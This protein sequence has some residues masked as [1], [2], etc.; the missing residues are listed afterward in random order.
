MVMRFL[1]SIVALVVV[2]AAFVLAPAP[3][4]GQA[5]AAKNIPRL[6]DGKPD[7]NGIWDR[8]RI[9]DITRDENACGSGAPITA[10]ASRTGSGELP[11][12]AW[13]QEQM[14]GPRFDYAA[15][16][17]PWGYTRAMQ[18]AYPIEIM[19]TPKRLAYLFESNNVFHVI[20]TDGRKLPENAD[21]P[22]W[23]RRPAVTKAT[24]SSSRPRVSMAG[25]GSTPRNIHQAISCASPN[26]SGS[27]TPIISNM[28]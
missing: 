10:A 6:A 28:K 25:P 22:G 17:L 2:T 12:T 24:R 8:P 11:Y 26:A 1:T 9:S 4:A 23:V 14:A 21:P 18:T 27:S 13:G 3:A 20:P 5:A 16:C 19:Q 15:R 7:F